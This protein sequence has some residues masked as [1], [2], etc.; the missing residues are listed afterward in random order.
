MAAAAGGGV[1]QQ[2]GWSELPDD[3][4]DAVYVGCS[5]AY[6]RA[7]F[8]AV[9][10][11]WRAVASLHPA[12]PALPLLLPFTGDTD[13]DQ[14][15]RA[16]SPED[17]R[18]LRVPLLWFPRGTR[19]VG[20]HDGGWVV[21]ETL[22]SG[23]S[24]INPFSGAAVA[25]SQKKRTICCRCR[26]PWTFDPT[27]LKNIVNAR[28]IVFSKEPSSTGCILAA[29][30]TESSEC[31]IALCTI[32]SPGGWTT[33]GCGGWGLI[34]T[35]LTDI[36]FCN[37]RLHGL[38]HNQIL[39]FDMNSYKDDTPEV[40]G[41]YKQTI[42]MTVLQ[43]FELDVISIFKYIFELHGKPVIAV[44]VGPRSG[45]C[46]DQFFRVFEL[47]NL[48]EVTS[49][50]DHALFLGPTGCKA[51]HMPGTGRR[52]VVERNHIYYSE[53]HFSFHDD[54]ESL[55]RLDLCGCVVYSGESEGIHR[56]EKIMSR[57]FHYL[58]K[59]S[60]NSCIWLLPPVN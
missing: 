21:G 6:D 8:R 27:S 35:V 20:G 15:T 7:R 23:I 56:L 45:Y 28:K 59:N 3:L 14:E 5:S 30:T 42:S 57:G 51:V 50:G 29:M 2:Q 34:R 13:H 48:K 22:G 41:V 10:R 39:I 53:G 11:S 47:Y 43:F 9:C 25:L 18:A 49:L 19:L 26:N 16:Y 17:G 4:L 58:D 32:G 31:K 46:K 36:A 38:T 40:T 60:C 33:R 54:V 24:I 52:G 1:Q 12:L 55:P 37:G 44:K